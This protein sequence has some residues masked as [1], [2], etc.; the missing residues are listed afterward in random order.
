[1]DTTYFKRTFGVTV[2]R[3]YYKRE[4]LFWEFV[5]YETVAKYV[6]GIR[7]LQDRGFEIMG[8]VIDGRRG[9]PEAFPDIPIQI[10]QFHQLQ[11]IRRYLTNHPKLEAGIELKKT[12]EYLTT[13]DKE[14]FEGWLNEW[15][16]KWKDFL[17]ERTINPE[18]KRWNYTHR[19]LRSAYYSLKTNLKYL[20]TYQ[21]FNQLGI[22][23]TTNSLEGVFSH[24]KSKVR[25]HCGLKLDRKMKLIE[26][27]LLRNSNTF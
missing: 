24:I 12:C 10:C 7:E 26:Q 18:T 14:S 16:I 15:F 27:L 13:T 19:N 21:K 22:P 25:A 4:N 8:I 17:S 3:D 11:I 2:F 1:M 23:N 6:N 5:K 20:F 9:L